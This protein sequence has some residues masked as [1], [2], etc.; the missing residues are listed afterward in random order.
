M[1]WSSE[2]P[3]LPVVINLSYIDEPGFFIRSSRGSIEV[4]G[5]EVPRCVIG[6]ISGVKHICE[7][8]GSS[9]AQR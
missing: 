2:I 6:C 7:A 9:T 5:C 4:L 1:G 8:R 3:C